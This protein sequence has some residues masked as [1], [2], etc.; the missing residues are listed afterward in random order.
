GEPVQQDGSNTVFITDIPA[1]GQKELSFQATVGNSPKLISIAAVT[2]GIELTAA[3]K[4]AGQLTWDLII[5]PKKK[6]EDGD[7]VSTKEDYAKAFQVLNLSFAK[8]GTGAV[9]D[10][11]KA[12]GNKS[13][14]GISVEV[15]LYHEGFI[16]FSAGITNQSAATSNMSGALICRWE[17]PPLEK[18]TMCYDNRRSDFGSV[19]STL[20][21]EAEGRHWHTQHGVDWVRSQIKGGPSVVWINPFDP[22]FTVYAEPTAKSP[23]RYMMGSQAQFGREAQSIPGAFFAITEI[24][25]PN[26]K[27][28]RD[29]V[30]ENVLPPKG[31]GFVISTR[32][33]LQEREVSDDTADEIFLGTTSYREQQASGGKIEMF[34]GVASVR[35]GTSYFPYSTLGEN[36]DTE[37]LLGMDREGFWPLAADT[38]QQWPLFADEIRRDLRLAKWMGFEL[39]RLHHLEL[40]AP[41]NKKVRQEYLDF[42]FGEMRHLG[43]KALLDVYASPQQMEEL[44]KRYGDAIDGV[45]IE[46]ETLIWNIPANK[47]AEWS[48]LYETVKKI[49]PHVKMHWTAQNN[50]GLFDRLAKTGVGFDRFGLHAYVDTLD[51]LP[52]ARGWALATGDYGT[53][54]GKP[55]IITEWNYRG[56]T[57]MTPEDRAKIYPKIFEG[58]LATRSISDFYQFQFQETL[59]PN[60]VIG[61]GNLLRHYEIF[62]L[63]RH[64]KMEALEF[65]KIIQH[66]IAPNSP[67]KMLA[68]SYSETELDKAGMGTANII[69][70]NQS[71]EALELKTMVEAPAELKVEVAGTEKISLA[72]HETKNIALKLATA[73]VKPGFYHA[74][75]RLEGTN[76][77]LRYAAV[78]AR[79]PGM[80]VFETSVTNEVTYPR[81]VAEELKYPF[82]NV[83][84]VVYGVDAPVMEVETAIA[85]AQTLESATGRLIPFLQLNDLPSAMRTSGNLILVGTAKSHELIKE[86]AAKL[87]AG[88]ASVVRVAKEKGCE[89]LVVS[90]ADSEAAKTAGMDL[91][92]RYWKNAK[93]SA[94]RKVGL[95]Q[96]KLPRGIDPAKLP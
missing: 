24:A 38:V 78:E 30:R 6:R 14:L 94:A 31:E 76:G 79:L 89:W 15:K 41:I 88:K 29:R 13:G 68:V 7:I 1:N 28:Y 23:G 34:F 12:T 35:F 52:S 22:V 91:T 75:V 37:K 69:I 19:A 93:D 57:R 81:G 56:L 96:K 65:E 61:R 92:V 87:P 95:V 71:G 77:F 32:L 58:A 63:S 18:R 55:P 72:P 64:P 25:R 3:G 36:F 54:I 49:A 80:P 83:A 47:T 59:S 85:I 40:L 20:F 9:F 66:Y 26:I 51:A 67:A 43:M 11:W 62:N 60:P 73:K 70:T 10:T 74:F 84:A 2:N 33:A 17:H 46:N 53:R 48:Q 82:G 16:D 21:H 44:I 90:G 4:K 86:V 39:I 45:E 5:G 50:T 8:A 42:L 27:S